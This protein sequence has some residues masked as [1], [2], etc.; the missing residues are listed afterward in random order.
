MIVKHYGAPSAVRWR[1]DVGLSRAE[2]LKSLDNALAQWA[3]EMRPN[4]MNKASDIMGV[5]RNTLRKILNGRKLP[6]HPVKAFMDSL[7]VD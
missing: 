1:K 6:P 7:R 3:L 2:V 4:S 5:N